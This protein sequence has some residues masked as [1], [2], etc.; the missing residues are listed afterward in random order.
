MRIRRMHAGL[1]ALALMTLAGCRTADDGQS[2]NPQAV[3]ATSTTDIP[4]EAP[5]AGAPVGSA[6]LTSATVTPPVT[7]ISHGPC[8]L[9]DANVVRRR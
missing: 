6:E 1:A 4:S 5:I 7:P 3:R 9:A 2:S 8:P